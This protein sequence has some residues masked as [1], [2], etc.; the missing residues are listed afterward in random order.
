MYLLWQAGVDAGW[1]GVTVTV[2]GDG[3]TAEVAQQLIEQ[4]KM[5][6]VRLTGHGGLL[7]GC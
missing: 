1:N 3:L 2:S 7:A 6:G 5:D 4:A